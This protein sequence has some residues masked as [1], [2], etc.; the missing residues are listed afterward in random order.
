ME[1][2]VSVDTVKI[3]IATGGVGYCTPKCSE[4]AIC[5]PIEWNQPFLLRCA[6]RADDCRVATLEPAKYYK[7]V[8][9]HSPQVE[10]T[11]G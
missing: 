2:W 6:M 1:F 10:T 5:R 11:R 3:C 7:D 9:H 8:V 4:N